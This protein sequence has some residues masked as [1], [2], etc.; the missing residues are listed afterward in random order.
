MLVYTY[1]PFTTSKCDTYSSVWLCT[2]T[3][4]IHTGLKK[5]LVE[6]KG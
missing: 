1:I 5:E 3:V 4:Y 6:P 2:V